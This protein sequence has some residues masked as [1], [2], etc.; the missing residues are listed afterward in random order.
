M[1]SKPHYSRHELQNAARRQ[2]LL[3]LDRGGISAKSHEIGCSVESCCHPGLSD[4]YTDG[5]CPTSTQK[6]RRLES[7]SAWSSPRA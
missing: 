1:E 7:V 6:P 3:A 5:E 2:A 4:L